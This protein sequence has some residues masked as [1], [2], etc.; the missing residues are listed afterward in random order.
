MSRM[1]YAVAY[2]CPT[3]FFLDEETVGTL[4]ER[5]G[6]TEMDEPCG[7][8]ALLADRLIVFLELSD[9]AAIAQVR[10]WGIDLAD[11]PRSDDDRD[12]VENFLCWF[13]NLQHDHRSGALARFYDRPS[14][15]IEFDLS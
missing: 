4:L 13:H 9:Q 8:I 12:T 7:R 5:I 2:G 10:E 15:Y 3:D 14:Q 6:D 11:A 1:M